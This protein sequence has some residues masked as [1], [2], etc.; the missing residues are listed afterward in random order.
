MTDTDPPVPA[1][2]LARSLT[3]GQGY[4]KWLDL[5]ALPPSQHYGGTY[6]V[7]VIEVESLAPACRWNFYVGHTAS[8]VQ[9]RF[10]QH[11]QG[12]PL[13]ARIFCL[14]GTPPRPR[15]RAVRLRE[16][17]MLG[18]PVFN[19]K[20]AAMQAEGLLARM[21]EARGHRTKSDAKNKAALRRQLHRLRMQTGRYLPTP[22][23]Y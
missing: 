15:A 18:T 22:G 17:L 19:S 23:A 14:T 11:A 21:L 12:G 6:R 10:D 9:K 8:P 2:D 3:A 20:E 4:A 1:P 13:A 7:Y 5:V 16:D